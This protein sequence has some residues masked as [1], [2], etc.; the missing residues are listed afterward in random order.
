MFA[1]DFLDSFDRLVA[2]DAE[3]TGKHAPSAEFI[4]KQPFAWKPPGVVKVGGGD[5]RRGA[6]RAGL[7][8]HPR[9]G[10]RSPRPRRR[11]PSPV[12]LTR[13]APPRW[14]VTAVGER[15]G[16][17]SGVTGLAAGVARR[18]SLAVRTG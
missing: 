1:P 9:P 8:L 7:R 4:R 10:C 5:G 14:F 16:G 3:T 15:A 13:P 17:G 11:H 12:A 18:Q 2:F 6:Q